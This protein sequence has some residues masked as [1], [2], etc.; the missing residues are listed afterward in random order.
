MTTEEVLGYAAWTNSKGVS[1][2]FSAWDDS[3]ASSAILLKAAID[4]NGY[5]G[6]SVIFGSAEYAVFIMA[7]AASIDWNRRQGVINFAF[8]HQSG[9]AAV[10]IDGAEASLLEAGNVNYYGR[11]ATRNPEFVSCTM[12]RYPGITAILTHGLMLSGY[13]LLFRFPAWMA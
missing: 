6:T 10:V 8:K 2:L 11:W 9:L 1:Y 4:N 5:A 3:S 13:A 12:A 7:E